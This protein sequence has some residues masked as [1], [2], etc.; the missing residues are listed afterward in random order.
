MNK[1]DDSAVSIG[2]RYSR[3]DE[4]GTPFA[5]TIDFQTVQDSSVTLRERD[6][7]KQI[8]ESVCACET[9]LIP[10]IPVILDVIKDL[11]EE[12]TT[13]DQVMCKFP[14]FVEQQI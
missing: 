3:N 4:L 7:T 6:S 12:K 5:I 11:C 2:K 13:W 10:Q 8:R 1:T 14:A 9:N